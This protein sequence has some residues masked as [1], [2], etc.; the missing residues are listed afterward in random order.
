M[1]MDIS[2]PVELVTLPC[3]LVVCFQGWDLA[4]TSQHWGLITTT[5]KFAKLPLRVVETAYVK[6][7]AWPAEWGWVTDSC[8]Y[9]NYCSDLRNM[10]SAL[11]GSPARPSTRQNCKA[12]V[13]IP[14]QRAF[15]CLQIPQLALWPHK[16]A[17]NPAL[18]TSEATVGTGLK[19]GENS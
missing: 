2:R 12:G 4:L 18:I 16:P 14:G 1:W 9:G 7:V 13:I 3:T 10:Y 17:P 6:H 15:W 19:Q 8:Y 5:A 11:W